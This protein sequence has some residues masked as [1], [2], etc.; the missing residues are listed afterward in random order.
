M[1]DLDL[2]EPRFQRMLM[3]LAALR[4]LRTS[5]TRREVIDYIEAKKW[6][7]LTTEDTKPYKSQKSEP[8][9]KNLIAWAR[10]NCVLLG[11]MVEDSDNSWES[12]VNGLNVVTAIRNACK[13][14]AFEVNKCF[15]W[16][17]AMKKHFDP[18]HI[19]SEQDLARPR[20]LYRDSIRLML[21]SP[22]GLDLL[23]KKSKDS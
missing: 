14:N 19:E 22:G 4:D 21:K 23:L 9:W 2:Y 20:F 6:Y 1:K 8:R 11:W 16:T 13:D 18:S 10:K 5:R 17:E 3:L 7:D 15:L 12:T